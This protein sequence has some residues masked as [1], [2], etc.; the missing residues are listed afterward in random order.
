MKQFTLWL[1]EDE[2]RPIVRL[3]NGV[4][5]DAMLD[6]GAVFPIWVSTKERLLDIGG[7][8]DRSDIPFGGFGGLTKGDL[9]RIPTF[10]VGDL[11]F[12]QFPVILSPHDLPC[13]ILLSATMFNR[14]VYE[15]DDKNHLLNFSI[16]DGESLV[17]PL[18]IREVNG[19]LQIFC[20]T[21]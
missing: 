21:E 1:S 10:C 14:L 11:V 12:P 5:L 9:Y 4:A 16:P 19:R 3:R 17:R 13:Q 2:Q 6:T 8:F 18:H 20:A 7:T 15:V